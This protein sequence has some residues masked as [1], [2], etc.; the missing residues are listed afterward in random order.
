MTTE[1]MVNQIR[2]NNQ[3]LG[4]RVLQA[5]ADRLE[6]QDA[7]LRSALGS[8]VA[9]ENENEDIKRR[10]RD[11][12]E[13]FVRR[14]QVI[15]MLEREVRGQEEQLR[16]LGSELAESER[17]RQI[18]TT[19]NKELLDKLR[20][21]SEACRPVAKMWAD[22]RAVFVLEDVSMPVGVAFDAVR[23]EKWADLTAS[24]LDALCGA[25]DGACAGVK[26]G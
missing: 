4:H 15:A 19:Q 21:L 18:L 22:A 9:L 6:E 11:R 24:Q 2:A 12:E 20:A 23:L 8:L 26:H 25:L 7:H 1:Q 5:I 3:A 16:G 10:H 17:H 13:F 14:G